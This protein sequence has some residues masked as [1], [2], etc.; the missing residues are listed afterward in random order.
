MSA[1]AV[2]MPQTP[3]ELPSRGSPTV[4]AA[5]RPAPAWT[6]PR[7]LR[8]LQEPL[9]FPAT[10]PAGGRRPAPA[11]DAVARGGAGLT[12]HPGPAPSSNGAPPD[13]LRHAR[14]LALAVGE[15]IQ[16]RRPA[17]QLGHWFDLDMTQKMQRRVRWEQETAAAA[18]AVPV[19]SPVQ[20]LGC[21]VQLVGEACEC[22]ATLFIGRQARALSFRLEWRRRRWSGVEVELG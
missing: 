17:H 8:P 9:P 14:G 12:P 20:V 3:I 6:Q 7:P 13:A 18:G 10:V 1:E 22:T 11:G 4:R 15:V 5:S 21:H 19:S 16:G 2:A